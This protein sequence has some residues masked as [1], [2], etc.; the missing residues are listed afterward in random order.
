[1]KCNV[2]NLSTRFPI[3]FAENAQIRLESPKA[4]SSCAG[5]LLC[6]QELTRSWS[7]N[8]PTVMVTC[9]QA[10][11]GR[12]GKRGWLSRRTR[13]RSW[14]RSSSRVTTQTSTPG[15]SWPLTWVSPRA[16]YRWEAPLV[17]IME[18]AAALSLCVNLIKNWAL[19]YCLKCIAMILQFLHHCEIRKYL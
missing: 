18:S 13:W 14:R 4:G 2:L 17:N 15:S 1:M 10:K 11:P 5:E 16:A 19:C 7:G 12:S 3:V 6:D 9:L 8:V